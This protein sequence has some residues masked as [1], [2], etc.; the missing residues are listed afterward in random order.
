[1]SR[2]VPPALPGVKRSAALHA[3]DLVVS[4][5]VQPPDALTAGKIDDLIEGPKPLTASGVC[6]GALAPPAVAYFS[7]TLAPA[8]SSWALALSACSLG[9]FSSTGLGAE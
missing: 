6:G 9:T 7:S 4:T 8:P 3:S 2:S 5:M 1:M